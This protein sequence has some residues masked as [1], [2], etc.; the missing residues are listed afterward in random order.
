MLRAVLLLILAVTGFVLACAYLP[1]LVLGALA[2]LCFVAVALRCRWQNVGLIGPV[3]YAELLRTTR[4]SRLWLLRFLYLGVVFAVLLQMYNVEFNWRFQQRPTLADLARFTLGLFWAFL[5]VQ[6]TTLLVLTPALTAGCIAE[7]RER[8]S[9]AFLLATDLR[10]HEI[11]LGKFLARLVLLCSFIL[12]GLPIFSLLQLLGGIDLALVGIAFA[13][14]LVTVVGV[15]S[16]GL[17]TSAFC[18]TTRGAI[19]LAYVLVLAYLILVPIAAV[20][21]QRNGWRGTDL[22]AVVISGHPAYA[23]EE[24][25][26]LDSGPAFLALLGR[27]ALFHGALAALCIGLAL[28]LVRRVGVGEPTPRRARTRVLPERV[29]GDDPVLW[30]EL[31]TARGWNER[32]WVHLLVVAGVLASLLLSD[33]GPYFRYWINGWCRFLSGLLGSLMLLQVVLHAA[34]AIR[35][36]RDRDTLDGLLTTPLTARAILSGKW[37]GAFWCPQVLGSG[38][39]TV[40]A[41][42]LGTGGLHVLA[43]LGQFVA[44]CIFAGALASFG[45][46]VSVTMSTALRAMLAAVGGTLLLSFGHWGVWCCAVGGGGGGDVEPVIFFQAGFTPPLALGVTFGFSGLGF[47]DHKREALVGCG[48][49]GSLCWICIGMVCWQATL[50]TFLGQLHRPEEDEF[51]ASRDAPQRARRD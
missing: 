39:L 29:V 46:L 7:E 20:Q 10:D 9:M 14:T 11:V 13:G 32:W 2:G 41:V 45:L 19:V 28:I 27:Y 24:F 42:G 33:G 23:A 35:S 18:R 3:F 47:D 6:L 44:L 31:W 34:T 15:G 43:I 1:P 21:L 30:R 26:R 48:S 51:A 50:A 4:C 22:E 16:L 17:L 25:A 40:W 37:F 12:A 8:K 5:V 49:F 36:E 38:L